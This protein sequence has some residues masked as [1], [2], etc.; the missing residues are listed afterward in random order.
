MI[1]TLNLVPLL[2]SGEKFKDGTFK[3][4]RTFLDLVVDGVSLWERLG[5]RHDMVSLLCSDFAELET[6]NGVDRILLKSD[7]DFANDRRSLFVCAECG[8]L[9]CGAITVLVKR[10]ADRVVWDDFGHENTY[11]ERLT[12]D[13]YA[14]VGPFQFEFHQYESTFLTALAKLKSL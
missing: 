5:K 12:S 7:A 10:T 11:E 4:Q 1:S 2:R 6:A 8:D 14:D 9:G 13:D 3:S